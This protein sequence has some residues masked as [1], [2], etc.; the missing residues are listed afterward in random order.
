VSRRQFRFPVS[1]HIRRV[2]IF[3]FTR[4]AEKVYINAVTDLFALAFPHLIT[5]C[6][7][8]SFHASRSTDLTRLIWVPIPLWMPEQRIQTKTPR[9]QEAHRGSKPHFRISDKENEQARQQ[10]KG[11]T[12]LFRLQSAQ[13]L[14]ASNFSR[15]LIVC[16]FCAARSEVGRR[17]MA[18]RR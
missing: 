16:W 4:A 6:S 14:L 3:P 12:R 18:G 17:D 2:S 5:L 8:S 11:Y 9:F 15:F 1:G 7:C 10:R 13:V